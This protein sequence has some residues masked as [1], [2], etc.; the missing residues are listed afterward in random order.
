MKRISLFLEVILLLLVFMVGC[1]PFKEN[2]TMHC[3]PEG[4]E[5][6]TIEHYEECLQER[7]KLMAKKINNY[8]WKL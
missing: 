6:K 8:Y 4:M 2:F 3:I 5:N 1:V 7:R